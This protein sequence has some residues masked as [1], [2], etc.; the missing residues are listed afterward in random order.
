MTRKNHL[1][2]IMSNNTDNEYN[3]WIEDLVN[4]QNKSN[5]DL[6]KPDDKLT[7]SSDNNQDPARSAGNNQANTGN[8][9]NTAS[10]PSS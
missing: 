8:K 7:T 9:S 1:I 10:N 3:K 2:H 4:V 6:N 5:K